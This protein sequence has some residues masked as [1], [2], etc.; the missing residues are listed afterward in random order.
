MRKRPRGAA[1][2]LLAK[3]K[4]RDEIGVALMIFPLEKIEQ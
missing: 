3:T 2:W 1:F 4:L